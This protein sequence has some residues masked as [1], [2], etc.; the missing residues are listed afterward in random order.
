MMRKELLKK[1]GFTDNEVDVLVCLY[2]YGVQTAQQVAEQLS[3]SKSSSLFIL[4]QLVR[5]GFVEKR[6]RYNT[7]LFQAKSPDLVL[8]K[9]DNNI[10]SLKKKREDLELLV[11]DLKRLRDYES[12]KR[13]Y[14]YDDEVSVKRLRSGLI[15]AAQLGAAKRTVKSSTSVEK[16]EG[17]RYVYLISMNDNFAIRIEPKADFD[18]LELLFKKYFKQPKQ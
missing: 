12:G 17:D 6:S 11:D 1:V 13:I 10:L 5:K 4:K 2:T 7:F 9:L 8:Q 16:F 14:Y 15:D 18:N 3:I